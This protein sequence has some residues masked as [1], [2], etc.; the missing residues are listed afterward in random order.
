MVYVVVYALANAGGGGAKKIPFEGPFLGVP[1]LRKFL[2]AH[3]Y[4]RD[5]RLVLTCQAVKFIV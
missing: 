5:M 1:P 3:M 4:I 2:R